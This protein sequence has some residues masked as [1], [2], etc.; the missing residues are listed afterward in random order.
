MKLGNLLALIKTTSKKMK[1]ASLKDL[2]LEAWLRAR[3]KGKIVW[4]TKNGDVIP[5][6]DMDDLHL[7]NTIK[8][9]EKQENLSAILF[10]ALDA[11]NCQI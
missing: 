9:L 4:K 7:S 5:I 10:D 3:D 1:A 11:D 2:K 8:M 6:K